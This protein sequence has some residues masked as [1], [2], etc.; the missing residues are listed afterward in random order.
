[1]S[2]HILAIGA[3]ASAIMATVALLSLLIKPIRE[4]LLGERVEKEATKEA[5]KCLIRSHIVSIYYKHLNQCELHQ[6]EYENLSLLYKQY[7]ALGGNSFIDKI[8]DEITENWTI[9]PG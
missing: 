8:Y 6:Y 7:K 5:L 3:I 9:I 1:M 4:K 2:T